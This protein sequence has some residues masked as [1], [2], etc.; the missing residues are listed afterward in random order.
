MKAQFIS[1]FTLDAVAI[2]VSITIYSSYQL[3]KRNNVLEIGTKVYSCNLKKNREDILE[4]GF[5]PLS[6]SLPHH[7]MAMASKCIDKSVE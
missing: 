6:K 1:F 7:F 3:Y 5:E 2:T 4:Q